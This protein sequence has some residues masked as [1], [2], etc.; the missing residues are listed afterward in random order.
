MN[1]I[2]LHTDPKFIRGYQL[3]DNKRFDIRNIL[4]LPRYQKYDFCETYTYDKRDIEKIIDLCNQSDLTVLFGLERVK[5]SILDRIKPEVKVV[6]RLFGAEIYNLHKEKFIED[7]GL[8]Y[9]DY[10]SRKFTQKIYTRLRKIFSNNY[11]YNSKNIRDYFHRINKIMCLHE[12][13]YFLLKKVENEIPDFL[14]IP[15]RIKAICE[16]QNTCKVENELVIG[17][18]RFR[19][20]NHISLITKIN[21]ELNSENYRFNILFNYGPFSEYAKYVIE[22]SQ[23]KWYNLIQD[24]LPRQEYFSMLDSTTGLVVNSLRENGMGSI[25]FALREGVKVYLNENGVMYNFLKKEG[26]KIYSIDD[27][28]KEI[29]ENN[30]IRYNYDE[31]LFNVNCYNRFASKH[32]LEEFNDDIEKMIKRMD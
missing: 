4:L 23:K 12:E 29:N 1:I 7:E 21:A 9:K 26:F 32:T 22:L 27:L 28:I 11:K 30:K 10:E 16:N 6:W 25:F 2:N 20:N 14:Q 13:E 19:H 3:F 24:V 8:K 18:N 15:L 17:A 31:A 5:L